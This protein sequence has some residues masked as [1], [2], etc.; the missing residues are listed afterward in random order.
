[1]QVPCAPSEMGQRTGRA[2]PIISE[3]WSRFI[4]LIVAAVEMWNGLSSFP[5]L[6]GSPQARPLVDLADWL[7]NVSLALQPGFAIAG[8][9]FGIISG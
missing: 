4:L 5:A 6:F 7:I 2:R 3:H 9:V 1:M 8:L